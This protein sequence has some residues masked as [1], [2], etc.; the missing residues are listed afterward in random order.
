MKA[1]QRKVALVR[2]G[3]PSEGWAIKNLRREGWRQTKRFH[4]DT[5]TWRVFYKGHVKSPQSGERCHLM[6]W[7]EGLRLSKVWNL[8]PSNQQIKLFLT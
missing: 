2:K 4:V 1:K 7:C 6:T 3:C 5:E 8:K